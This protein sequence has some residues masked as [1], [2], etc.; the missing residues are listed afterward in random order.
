MVT[1]GKLLRKIDQQRV[2]EALRQAELRTTGHIRVSVAP[3]FW[4]D[5]HKAAEKAFVRLGMTET[6]H[7]NA[8]LFF[9][10]PARRKLVVLGDSGIHETVGQQFW[11]DVVRL[12]LDHFRAG[13]FTGGLIKGI[14]AAAD[15]LATHFPRP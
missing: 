5:V 15:R 13:E 2:R 9:V 4:G 6:P 11:H 7:R 12:V 1:R 8:V 3:L 14:D 10:A